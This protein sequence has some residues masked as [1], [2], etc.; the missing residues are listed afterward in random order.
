MGV[1]QLVS[2]AKNWVLAS[3]NKGKIKEIGELL[4]PYGIALQSAA[5]FSLPDPA[6]T[7]NSFAGN[8]LLKARAAA[9]ATNRPALA[10]DSGLCVTALGG[11]PGIHSARWAG[12]P[13]DFGRAMQRIESELQASGSADRHA[14]FVCVLAL[15]FPDGTHRFYEGRIEGEMVWPPRGTGGFGYDPVFRPAGEARVFAEMTSAE[16]AALSHRGRA[17]AKLMAGEFG[18]D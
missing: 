5:D 11:Q 2:D 7:E 10:D 1:K 15:A 14:A 8:A 12:E 6:E 4:A 3:H 17:L 18:N 16:K 13:R 9:E